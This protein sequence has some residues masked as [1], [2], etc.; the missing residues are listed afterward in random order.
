MKKRI[1]TVIGAAAL[2]LSMGISALAA[3]SAVPPAATPTVGYGYGFCGGGY[4]LMWDEDGNFLDQ[5]AFEK[6]L[7]SLIESGLIRA[8]DRDFLL[9]RYEWCS[10]NG[11]GANGVRGGC[12]GRGMG[13]RMG[14][15]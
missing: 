14:N 10:T 7:D 2:C 15:F 13:W 4:S 8:E 9:E 1:V 6:N 11:G 3:P 5:S 12:G